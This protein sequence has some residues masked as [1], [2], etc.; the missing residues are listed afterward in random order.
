ML[1]Q[2]IERIW[3]IAV[4]FKPCRWR[5]EEAV[6]KYCSQIIRWWEESPLFMRTIIKRKKLIIKRYN[7]RLK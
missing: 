3:P 2:L 4:R 1:L 5:H 7:L 6:V